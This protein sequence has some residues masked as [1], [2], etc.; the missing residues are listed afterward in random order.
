MNRLL[1]VVLLLASSTTLVSQATKPVPAGKPTTTTTPNKTVVSPQQTPQGP[2]GEV[3]KPKDISLGDSTIPGDAE[4]KSDLGDLNFLS[5]KYQE[6]LK[7]FQ[8]KLNAKY[9]PEWNKEQQQI[10]RSIQKVKDANKWGDDVVFSAETKQWIKLVPKE[11]QAMK[12]ATEAS[13]P[14]TAQKEQP[15]K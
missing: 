11:V 5:E 1:T 9:G 6:E 13:A 10:Q 3:V 4:V 15:K 14:T 12:T 8:I 2:A 7:D